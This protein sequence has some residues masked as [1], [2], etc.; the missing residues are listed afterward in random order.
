MLLIDF[1]QVVISNLMVHANKNAHKVDIHDVRSMVLFSLKRYMNKFRKS[2]GKM[3][4]CVDGKH[5]W[6]KKEFPYY[7]ENRKEQKA[8]S[9]VDW[10]V[11]S[12]VIYTIAKE[13]YLYFPYKVISV[14]SAE[15]DDCIAV[16]TKMI[17]QQENVII[18]SGDKDLIQLQRFPNV[19]N[20]DPVRDRYLGTDDPARYLK[21][22]ILRGDSGD[23][24]PNFMSDDDT[25]MN[26]G[27]RQK[28]I[29][30]AKLEVWLDDPDFF[31]TSE[32]K[33]NIQRNIKLI[34]LE[35]VPEELEVKIKRQFARDPVGSKAKIMPYLAEKRLNR[36]VESI[37][38]F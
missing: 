6:R 4:I 9:P 11:V 12:N 19:L 22:H 21:E 8:K 32:F 27:K 36:L 5:V 14:D 28:S 38:E 18:I 13:L 37:G 7:K 35:N 1:N 30:A 24:V 16:L 15:S 17:S 10:E 2:H 31:E 34:D 33:E 20:Y 29:Y 25:F 3:V 26:S 23:G